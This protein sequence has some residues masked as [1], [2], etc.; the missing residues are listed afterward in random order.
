MHRAD[1]RRSFFTGD[2]SA[3]VTAFADPRSSGQ[4]MV[5]PLT[6]ASHI[7]D[8]GSSI[9]SLED[10]HEAGQPPEVVQAPYM[11]MNSLL[12]YQEMERNIMRSSA[13]TSFEGLDFSLLFERLL[14]EKDVV[15]EDENW[16]W[17]KLIASV[18]ANLPAPKQ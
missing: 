10:L 4:T 5:R 15:M 1:E 16:T 18:S 9:P 12:S 2:S 14:P 8:L 7:E 3:G 11:A 6:A 13:F 17:D